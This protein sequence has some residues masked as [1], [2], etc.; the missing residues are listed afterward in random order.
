MRREAPDA[1]QDR[2]RGKRRDRDDSDQVQG[3]RHRES[4]GIVF[5]FG[6]AVW[7]AGAGMVKNPGKP[8][9]KVAKPRPTR[10]APNSRT[11]SVPLL[12]LVKH[13]L[14]DDLAGDVA[15][16]DLAGKTTIADYMVIASGR[17]PRHIGAMADHL[18][19]RIKGA[20]LPSPPIEGQAQAEWVLIDGGDVIVHLFRPES[21]VHYNLEKI[22]GGPWTEENPGGTA[23]DG[24]GPSP[25]ET[26]GA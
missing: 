17:N 6:H 8:G 11:D 7:L 5:R 16:I 2:P 20:G 12:D 21:R 1:E 19:E 3:I 4:P 24:A 15:V 10:R 25:S 22:W 13:S 18:K 23:E 14:D 26:A 9:R